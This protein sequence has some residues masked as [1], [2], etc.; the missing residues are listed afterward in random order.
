MSAQNPRPSAVSAPAG[1]PTDQSPPCDEDTHY[2]PSHRQGESPK[3]GT[4]CKCGAK[5]WTGDVLAEVERIAL[6]LE[7]VRCSEHGL[8]A[9]TIRDGHG[10]VRLTRSKC[11]GSWDQTVV[12]WTMTPE[13]ARQMADDVS[14][15][16]LLA[17]STPM[18]R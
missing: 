1:E 7:V 16:A 17:A 3:M 6:R 9:V 2:W 11:C 14:E 12:A 5:R 13:Q 4:P 15:F 10:G 18:S 8:Y